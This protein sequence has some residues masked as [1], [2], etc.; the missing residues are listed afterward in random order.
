MAKSTVNASSDA[1]LSPKASPERRKLGA[2]TSARNADVTLPLDCSGPGLKKYAAPAPSPL[3][4]SPGA[5][6]RSG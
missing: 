4:S 5:P 1:T 3:R 2:T 6:A